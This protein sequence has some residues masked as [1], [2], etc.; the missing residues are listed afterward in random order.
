MT[1]LT[2]QD[3]EELK[4]SS[5]KNLKSYMIGLIQFK[6][7]LDLAEKELAKFPDQ[8]KEVEKELEEL[9]SDKDIPKG[10]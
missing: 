9:K 3:W 5:E 10:S 8:T 6:T 7:L 2:R 4:S 1:K